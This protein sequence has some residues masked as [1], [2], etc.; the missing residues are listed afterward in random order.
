MSVRSIRYRSLASLALAIAASAVTVYAPALVA[1][2]PTAPSPARPATHTV[3]RGDTLWDIAK[4]YLGDPF[5]WPD[6]YR[7]NTDQIEDPHW[8]YPGEVLKLPGE[9]PKVVAVR[10]VEPPAAPA[11]TP[12]PARPTPAPPPQIVAAV[13]APDTTPIEHPP[14]PVPTVRSG[15]YIAAPWVDRRG[16]PRG[17]G[18]VMG[19]A[20][21]PGIA[22][23]DHSR[24]NL[25][26]QV[27]VAPPAGAVAPEHERYLTYSFG[28]LLEDLGQV[29]IPTGIIEITRSARNGEAAIGRV[30]KLF[31]EMLEGQQLIALDSAA[32][33]GFEK[34]RAVANGKMGRVRWVYGS[35]VL[36]SVQSYV[37]FD[38][39]QP[40]VRTGDQIDLIA[41]RQGP[42]DGRDLAIPEQHIARAQILRVTP[43]GASA[44]LLDQD[45]PKIEEG[46]T[47][48]VAAKIP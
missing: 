7:L 47:V 3:K 43:Y 20:D 1:Q 28:P 12:V 27:L 44:I 21:L 31:N 13:P 15:E 8:I 17:S 35:P 11:P 42:A 25:Y 30:V 5:L 22:S 34:P 14:A 32:A 9:A 46:T 39:R 48:R 40:N 16:G 33:I 2:Q 45:Q 23:A 36:A 29:I 24:L 26:D 4:L 41:P 38:I 37:L 6:I 19:S 18:T 10:P